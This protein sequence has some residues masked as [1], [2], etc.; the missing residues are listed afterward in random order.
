VQRSVIEHAA[1]AVRQRRR[2][3]PILVIAPPPKPVRLDGGPWLVNGEPIPMSN[4]QLDKL[5]DYRRPVGQL[6]YRPCR[7]IAVR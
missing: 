4:R 1:A 2:G 5:E 6:E 3:D 7:I